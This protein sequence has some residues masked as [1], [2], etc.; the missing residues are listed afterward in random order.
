MH[1]GRHYAEDRE[2]WEVRILPIG[3]PGVSD[4]D[5]KYADPCFVTYVML[6]NS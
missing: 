2:D 4:P 1:S 6:V 5:Y 3:V